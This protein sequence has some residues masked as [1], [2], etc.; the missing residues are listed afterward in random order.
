MGSSRVLLRLAVLSSSAGVAIVLPTV[1]ATK[2]KLIPTLNSTS[3]TKTY[4]AFNHVPRMT[5]WLLRLGLI[6]VDWP[7]RGCRPSSRPMNA[8]RTNSIG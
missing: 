1:G 7:R 5:T 4:R 6:V 2:L 3:T 8:A